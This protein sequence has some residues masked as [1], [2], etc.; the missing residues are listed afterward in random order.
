MPMMTDLC[1]MRSESAD[2]IASVEIQD[3]P[4]CDTFKSYYSLT[5]HEIIIDGNFND[6]VTVFKVIGDPP[7]A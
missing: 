5:T 2:Y 6:T 7:Q 3:Y 1:E 4:C